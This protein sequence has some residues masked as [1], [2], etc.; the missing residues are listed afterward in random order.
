MHI[1]YKNSVKDDILQKLLE[2]KI[3]NKIIKRESSVWFLGVV[4]DENIWRIYMQTKEN[5]IS[6]TIGL[7]YCAKQLLGQISLILFTSDIP[8]QT[9]IMVTLHG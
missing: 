7:L 3:S 4:L 8:T 1:F 5:K 9:L 6:K 2:L